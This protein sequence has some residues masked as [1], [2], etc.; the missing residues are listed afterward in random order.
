MLSDQGIRSVIGSGELVVKSERDLSVRASSICLH[1]SKDI[2]VFER[3][4][5]EVDVLRGGSYPQGKRRTIGVDG[6]VIAPGEFLLAATVENI[7]L[8]RRLVG[9]LSNISGLARLGLNTLLSTHVSPGF[10]EGCARPITLEVYNSSKNHI[11]IYSGMRVCHLMISLL[12][13]TATLGYDAQFPGKYLSNSPD[14]SEF[15]K[16]SGVS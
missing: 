11:R 9:G 4:E 13:A 7:G 10:G 14:V 12:E 8:S 3:T 5:A 6:Y 16:N 2:V 1:L 15:F